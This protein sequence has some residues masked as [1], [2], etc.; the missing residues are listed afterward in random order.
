MNGHNVPARNHS[1]AKHTPLCLQL[2]VFQRFLTQV[3]VA[4]A[5]NDVAVLVG[6]EEDSN[7]NA[8]ISQLDFH[9]LVEV[10]CQQPT[11]LNNEKNW[12]N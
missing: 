3:L 8:A 2:V 5:Q 1:Q 12:Q 10:A 7:Q 6:A 11:T 9:G 4:S